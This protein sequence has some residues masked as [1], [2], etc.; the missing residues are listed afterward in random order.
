MNNKKIYIVLTQTYTG[1]ART[2]KTITR[3]KYSHVSISFDKKCDHM[4]SFG[5]KWDWFPFIGI[6]KIEDIRKG[7]F[8][9]NPNAL[10]GIYEITVNE[11][12][13][14]KIKKKIKEIEN[15]NKGYNIIG[16]LLAEFRIKLN[17][18]KYYCSEF[19]F[20]VLSSKKVNL[21]NSDNV[22]FRPEEI[23]SGTTNKLI[24]EGF[25]RDYLNE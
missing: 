20:E 11:Y 21:V 17:R 15:D 23:V 2:I 13:Y 3:N 18:K 19:V 7:L 5:R 4:Y 25:I 1:I 14:K 16:L 12:K 9:N 10:I 22:L 6:F 8:Q 24:Y